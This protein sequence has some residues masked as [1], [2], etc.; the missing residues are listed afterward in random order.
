MTLD[1][2]ALQRRTMDLFDEV[3]RVSPGAD[4]PR[5]ER[6][7]AEFLLGLVHYQ[8]HLPDRIPRHIDVGCGGGFSLLL[9]AQLT[10]ESHG[11][12]LPEIIDEA[13]RF[14]ATLPARLTERITLTAAAAEDAE[15]PGT[16]DLVTTQ[17][18]LEHLNSI[19]A[20]LANIRRHLRE[21][22]LVIH[23][24]DNISSRSGW[25]VEYRLRYSPLYRLAH[26]LYR[27]GIG[28]TLRNPFGFTPPHE[29]RFG[30][31]AHELEEYRGERW[32]LRLFREGFSVIDYFQTQDT[33]WVFI[34]RPLG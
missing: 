19:P 11:I 3:K 7:T 13:R 18:V 28:R 10:D 20:T 30:T 15:L 26:S 24:L 17:Y 9:W 1:L 23:A 16:F 4:I 25:Y 29:P 12:D 22:G 5:F 14:Y 34:T 2:M 33:N 21:N 27:A 31:F 8:R 32:A 6:L